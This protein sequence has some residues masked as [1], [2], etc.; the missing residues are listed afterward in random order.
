MKAGLAI[1]VA[2]EVMANLE[3]QVPR[4]PLAPTETLAG[5]DFPDRL[6]DQPNPLPTS[7]A[8]LADLGS[9]VSLVNLETME[10]TVSLVDQENQLPRDP[11]D[12]LVSLASLAE[13]ASLV[14]Q[15]VLV[16][17]EKEVFVPNTAPW[18]VEFSSKMALDDRYRDIF[19]SILVADY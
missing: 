9:L 3:T 12:S 14:P 2:L 4:V 18:M 17:L 7:P 19:N 6:A 16:V 1:L 5:P 10:R 8:T 13:M 11:L 15:V